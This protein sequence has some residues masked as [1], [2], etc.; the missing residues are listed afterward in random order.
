MGYELTF[1][2]IVQKLGPPDYVMYT[3][4]SGHIASCNLSMYWENDEIRISSIYK[5]KGCPTLDEQRKGVQIERDTNVVAIFYG[6]LQESW[7]LIDEG[8][9]YILWP[10]FAD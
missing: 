6:L 1:E 3:P 8:G 10:G 7:P 5:R 4:G 9:P 2:S